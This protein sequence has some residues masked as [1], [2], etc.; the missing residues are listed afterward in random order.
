M[1]LAFV[2]YNLSYPLLEL[3]NTAAD[4][5]F[6]IKDSFLVLWDIIFMCLS[7]SGFC[8]LGQCGVKIH[9]IQSQTVQICFY[10][11]LKYQ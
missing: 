7:A 3:E 9:K 10:V 6:C 8:S 1:T 5:F 11:S 4:S 2:K